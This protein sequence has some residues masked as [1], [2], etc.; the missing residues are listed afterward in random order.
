MM[1]INL[2]DY[3]GKYSTVAYD[4]MCGLVF[5]RRFFYNLRYIYIYT[6]INMYRVPNQKTIFSNSSG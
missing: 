3:A 4:V 1:L 2:G 6:Y 5:R